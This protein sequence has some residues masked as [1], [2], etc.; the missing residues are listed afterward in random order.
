MTGPF[1]P[2][3]PEVKIAVLEEKLLVYEELSREMLAKLEVAVD[4]ISEANQS[5]S[6]I[7]VRHD[8]RLDQ[9]IQSDVA[10][11]KLLDEM[12]KQ[13]NESLTEVREVLKDHEKR[14]ADLTKIRWLVVGAVATVGFI[15]G[16]AEFFEKFLTPGPQP[17]QPPAYEYPKPYIPHPSPAYERKISKLL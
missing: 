16:K 12:K 8:E 11:I 9:A 17:A 1:F 14:I 2:K 4:K 3:N 5:I 15:M 13:N 10:I 7:L 6:K